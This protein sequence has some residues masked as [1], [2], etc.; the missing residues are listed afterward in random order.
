MPVYAPSILP[1]NLCCG[2][3]TTESGVPLSASDRTS[4]STVYFTPYGGNQ[5]ALY[6]G[7]GWGL[8]TFSEISLPLSGLTSGANYDLFATE[9]SGAVVLQLSAAWSSDSTRTDALALQDGV[10][11]KSGSPTRRYLGTLRTTGTSTTE[12]SQAKRLLWNHAHRLPR[13]LLRQ[14]GT[15]YVYSSTTRRQMNGDNAN[16]VELV[17]GLRE[18]TV[19]L[20]LNAP[21]ETNSGERGIVS[22]GEN[23]TTTVATG[24]SA[25]TLR[26][27]S[28]VDD[29][30]RLNVLSELITLPQLGYSN[31]TMLEEAFSGSVQFLSSALRGLWFC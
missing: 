17:Q 18:A 26:D 21:V 15:G 8:R 7:R 4:Q 25:A 9:S 14:T 31:Y 3:L 29:S 27:F 13:S 20:S 16:Q 23:S 10:Q 19:Q 12:D 24:C 6:D 22:I 28:A 5:I 11:V 1:L 30:K 2:R